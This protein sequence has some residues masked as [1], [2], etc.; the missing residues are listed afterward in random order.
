MNWKQ[1]L[2]TA[3]LCV[4]LMIGTL[5]VMGQSGIN[6]Y[7]DVAMYE[8]FRKYA[9]SVAWNYDAGYSYTGTVT[10]GNNT[11]VTLSINSAYQLVTVIVYVSAEA[12]ITYTGSGIDCVNADNSY[13]EIIP[14][15]K[16]MNVDFTNVTAININASAG[17]D[18]NY[19]IYIRARRAI[20]STP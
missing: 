10:S 17:S 4:L 19:E 13:T 5:S 20:A 3:L 8:A 6:T 18:V 12:S 9:L 15:G 2:A 7:T 16:S 14:A 1:V 11:D